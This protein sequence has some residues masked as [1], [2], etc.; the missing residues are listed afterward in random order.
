MGTS[1]LFVYSAH[2]NISHQ[3]EVIQRRKPQSVHSAVQGRHQRRSTVPDHVRHPDKYTCYVL[4]EPL[5]VGGGERGSGTHGSRAELE[6]VHTTCTCYTSEIHTEM[7][8]N[9]HSI[10]AGRL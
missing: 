4:D 7:L 3:S 8:L 10:S 1:I 6:Q 9:S 5:V 2:G